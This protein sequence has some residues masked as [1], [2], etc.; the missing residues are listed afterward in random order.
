LIDKA[1]V[2]GL[3]PFQKFVKTLD[4][5]KMILSENYES[6][7]FD[8]AKAYGDREEKVVVQRESI[9]QKNKR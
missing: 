7:E 9:P 1:K 5:T 6:D 3:A 4:N 2:D 8:E